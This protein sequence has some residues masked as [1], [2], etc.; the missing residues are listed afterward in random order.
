[1]LEEETSGL[2]ST[3]FSNDEMNGVSVYFPQGSFRKLILL[4]D[5]LYMSRGHIE[6]RSV[7]QQY[8][9]KDGWGFMIK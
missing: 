5:T 3:R 9:T 1:M 4:H 8:D 2:L 6:L 7:T